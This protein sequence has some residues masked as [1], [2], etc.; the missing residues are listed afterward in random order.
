MKPIRVKFGLFLC[1]TGFMLRLLRLLFVLVARSFRSR[2]DLFLENLALRQQL[3]VVKERR[4]QP[5]FSSS[6]KLFWVILRRLW[7][8]WKRP[9]V[10]VQPETVV[11]WHRAGFKLY[12]TWLSRHRDHAGRKCINR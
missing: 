9:L 2:R 7:T 5:R 6:N 3:A 12:W 1:E 4:P 10:A 11:Q 8:G